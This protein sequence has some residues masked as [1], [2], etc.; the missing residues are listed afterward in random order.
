M[1]SLLL[2]PLRIYCA[3]TGTIGA[4]LIGIVDRYSGEHMKFLMLGFTC[5]SCK[6][7][8]IKKPLVADVVALDVEGNEVPM[9]QIRK[10]AHRLRCPKCDHQWPLR[11][12]KKS[13]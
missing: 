10:K 7:F 4:L 6:S 5:G 3:L 1:K 2:L 8:L 13:K 11:K 12:P 9:L